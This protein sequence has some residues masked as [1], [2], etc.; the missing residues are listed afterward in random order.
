M[1]DGDKNP[2]MVNLNLVQ[3]INELKEK[4]IIDEEQ[5]RILLEIKDVGNQ[6]G[7]VST[8]FIKISPN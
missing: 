8:L 4:N 5:R 6:T 1:L 2:V 7:V 3:K